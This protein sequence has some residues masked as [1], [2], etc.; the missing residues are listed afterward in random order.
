MFNIRKVFSTVMLSLSVFLLFYLINKFE[1]KIEGLNNK[2][3]ILYYTITLSLIFLSVISFFFNKKY[4]DYFIIIISSIIVTL[5]LY[6][7]YLNLNLL[8]VRENKTKIKLYE[9][10]T[11]K[12]YDTRTRLEFYEDSKKLEPN[13]SVAYGTSNFLNKHISMFPLSGI[14][15]SKTIY[16]N[17][18]GYYSIY[19]SDRYGFNNPDDEWDSKIT[20][21]LIIGDSFAHGA[22]VNRPHDISSVLRLL[23]KKT[24][25]N[26]GFS[27][28]GPLSGYASL[29]EYLKPNTN[30]IIWLYYE[31]NDL[32]NLE[33]ELSNK[34][35]KKY[36]DDLTFS[37]NLQL[38]QKKI[39]E[40]VKKEIKEHQKLKKIATNG[41]N[42]KEILSKIKFFLKLT[43]LRSTLITK[44]RPLD[45]FTRILN[46]TKNLALKNNSTLY[47]VYLPTYARYKKNINDK[48]YNYIK[49]ISKELNIDF[50]DINEKLF[51]KE[52]NPLIYFPFEFYGHY[53]I[54]GYKKISE[55]IYNHTINKN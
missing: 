22:A 51:L 39:D 4:K 55:I 54:K 21:Y 41:N 7:G 33:W 19:N 29:R 44:T 53:N 10:K 30:K 46:L 28:N 18:N 12:K 36:Y 37:Q 1:L 27:G 34:I 3:I 45:E 5:Y 8:K 43:K 16:G 20:E 38:N 49:N 35:L 15:N 2:D 50:I 42:K 9:E 52:K 25:L 14:S 32:V 13:I 26:L 24:V 31:G 47:L 40:I 23:S 48:N 6:E 17:E 11:G